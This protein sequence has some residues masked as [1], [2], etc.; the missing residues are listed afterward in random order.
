MIYRFRYPDYLESFM[1]C[2]EQIRSTTI[3]AQPHSNR[4]QDELFRELE[5]VETLVANEADEITCDFH[6]APLDKFE[7]RSR[8]SARAHVR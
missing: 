1:Q 2:G 5:L 3:S 6:R 4:P 8:Q 7:F